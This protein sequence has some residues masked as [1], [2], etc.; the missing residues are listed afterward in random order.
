MTVAALEKPLFFHPLFKERVWGGDKISTHLFPKHKIMFRCGES[1]VLSSVSGAVSKVAQPYPGKPLD[2]LIHEYKAQLMGTEVYARYGDTCPLL[3]KFIDAHE[4]LSVQVHPN[5][6]LA[7]E[8]HNCLGKTEMWYALSADPQAY[9]ISG[10]KRPMTQ[11]DYQ[12]HLQ[13]DTLLEQL[14]TEPVATGDL[15]FIPAGR[16]HSVGKGILFAE[17]Q[18]CSDITYR[19][20]DFNRVDSQG[21][22]RQLHIRESYAALDFK[23]VG[24]AKIPYKDQPNTAIQLLKADPFVVHK[25]HCQQGRII[26]DMRKIDS[27]VLYLCVAGEACW[28]GKTEKVPLQAGDCILVPASLGYYGLYSAREGVLLEA[29]V[30]SMS[31]RPTITL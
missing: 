12:A 31:T 3:V 11:A 4:A 30:P 18:Q 6:S 28:E 21:Q 5:D 10:F 25:L 7:F 24:T 13:R 14:Y 16:I 15:F 2:T 26:R 29:Y 9:V 27:F 8:R 17:I 19:I 22:P 23:A 1:W 20:H